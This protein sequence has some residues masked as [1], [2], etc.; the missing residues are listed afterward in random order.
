[1][2]RMYVGY[3]GNYGSA[4]EEDIMFFDTDDLTVAQSDLLENDPTEF[5]F[6]ISSGD[7][8]CL[9]KEDD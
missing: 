9:E 5:Y 3:D 1:M 8:S 7:W 2:S 6:A 4:Q